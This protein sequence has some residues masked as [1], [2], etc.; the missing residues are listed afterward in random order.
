MTAY[1]INAT[2]EGPS[3]RLGHASLLV[4]NAFIGSHA[5]LP[6]LSLLTPQFSAEN[7]QRPIYHMMIHYTC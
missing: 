4:G 1:V 2:G 5:Q 6:V 7:V 3:P